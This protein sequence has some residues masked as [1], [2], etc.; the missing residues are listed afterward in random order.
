MIINVMW[1]I[2]FDEM[3]F[4]LELLYSFLYL[5]SKIFENDIYILY[6][7]HF[8]FIFFLLLVIKLFFKVY[9]NIY[10]ILLGLINVIS[11]F[12]FGCLL[13]LYIFYR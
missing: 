8:F 11:F 3:I 7:D 13:F 10:Y 6:F 9:I 1:I 5:I 12:F 4:L 2:K